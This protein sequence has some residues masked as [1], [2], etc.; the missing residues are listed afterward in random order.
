MCYQEENLEI[1]EQDGSEGVW[2]F[3]HCK[4]SRNFHPSALK[5]EREGAGWIAQQL[6]KYLVGCMA[7]EEDQRLS[8][9]THVFIV[10]VFIL[11]GFEVHSP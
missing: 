5:F 3:D 7:C 10:G 6:P 4:E 2:F 8:V 1:R 9:G 11:G